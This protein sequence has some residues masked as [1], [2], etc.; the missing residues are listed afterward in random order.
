MEAPLLYLREDVYFEPL[1]NQWYAWPYLIPP[2]TCARHLVNTHKRIMNSFINN[3]EL[4]QMAAIEPAM[5]GGEF[6]NCSQS[7]LSDIK[8]LVKKIDLDLA[9]MVTL[10]DAVKELDELLRN[11]ISG[12]SL[13]SMYP[14]VPEPLRGYVE[15]QMD[16]NH[17]ATFRMIESLLYHSEYYKPQLQSVAFGLLNCVKERPFV[18][19]TP[20]FPDENSL[21]A[22]MDFNHTSL[23]KILHAR[24]APLT[25]AEVEALF[26]GVELAGGLSPLDLF[27][28]LPPST[29]HKAVSD[30]VRLS[31]LGHAG[32]L[33]ETANV[34]ILV[35]PV[36]ATKDEANAD[37]VLSFADLPR[38][39]DYVLLTHNHQDHV[40]FESL[41]Q[42]RP[43]IK[44]IVVPQNNGGSLVDPSLKL[45][46]CQ[47]GFDVVAVEDMERITVNDGTITALPFLGE[48]G[49]LNIRSKA[50]WLVELNG[51]KVFLGADSSNLEPRMYQLIERQVGKMDVLAIGMECIGA[52][53]TWLY[54]A[55]NTKMVSK[56]V[57]ESRRLNGANF[58]QA[59]QMVQ[60]F[61]PK[62]VYLYALGMEPWYKYFMGLDYKD[63][64]EQIV[65]SDKMIDKCREVGVRCERLFGKKQRVFI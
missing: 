36:I 9:D 13:E 30:G 38:T 22:K 39:I 54:G 3:Y 28:E 29:N 62:E 55:L 42:L 48:H 27:S 34:S 49:D 20:R 44:Q 35:D 40:N 57:K 53:Y 59:F 31:Y 52:P 56:K 37:Q 64:S 43:R 18:L 50:A 19:S 32:F 12:E 14:K 46:L 2:L 51:K 11:H 8:A 6:L 7:Q 24:I 23:N 33:L 5:A 15:L 4:H 61:L 45:L 17:N 21:H 10:S 26:A 58:D 60:T 65:Q 25:Y 41:L 63:D 47:F 16:I 1:V